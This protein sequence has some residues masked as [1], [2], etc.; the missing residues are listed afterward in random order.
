MRNFAGIE[1]KYS[2]FE[3]VSTLL[4]SIPYDG[5]STWGKGADKAF[6]AFL[7]AAENMELYDIETD[8]EVYKSGI[9]ILPEIIEKSS[10]EAM[11]TAVYHTTKKIL[12]T[13]KFPTFFGGE[14]SVSIGI[15][16][17]FQEQYPNL[18]V[19]QLDAHADLRPE[20]GSTPYN[21]A[22]ALHEA[23][24]TTNLIQVGIRSMDTCELPYLNRK[25]CFFAEQIHNQTAWMAQS[26]ALMTDPVYITI[27]LDVFD[28][29]IMPSTGTPEPG[30]LDWYTVTRY[31]RQVFNQQQVVG[32]DIT[33]LA[34]RPELRA[35]DFL[36]AKLYYK[37]L[38]YQFE[39]NNNEV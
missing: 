18:T 8:S 4:Q 38:S 9:H 37:L 20:Y 14:H 15:I 28:P 25:Q 19:L 13:K 39:S 31:L 30:G 16:R 23:S 33:E 11:V 5:T 1:D 35:P 6:S 26:I 3:T 34:P 22:C 36:T 17:A 24:K 12:N 29:S 21:H 32:F 10:P 27:D 2:N 7:D